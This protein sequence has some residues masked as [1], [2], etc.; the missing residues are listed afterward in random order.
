MSYGGYLDLGTLLSAQRPLSDPGA[1]RRA[2]VH[3]PA[4][5]HRAVAEACA[6]RAVGGL[7]AAAGRSARARAE[8]HRARQAHPADS[9]RAVVGARDADPRRVRG[10]SADAGHASGFQSAQYRAIEFP[11]G[12]KNAGMLRV[13]AAD[14]VAHAM[15]APPSKRRACMTSSWMLARRATR[16]PSSVLDRDVTKAWSFTPSW[17]RSSRDLRRPAGRTGRRTSP[18]RSWS[19]SRTTSSCG[20]SVTSRPWSGSSASR[21]APAARAECVPAAGARAHLLPRAVR[22]AHEIKV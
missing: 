15:V 1:P 2:A 6:A 4:P 12:N 21:P 18:A 17:C 22:G 7:P 3:H 14:P 5:D 16:I 10:S 9:H 19:T 8:V 13:F 20:A 11:L